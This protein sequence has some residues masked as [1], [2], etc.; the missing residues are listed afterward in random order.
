MSKGNWQ[1]SMSEDDKDLTTFITHRCMYRFT[2]MLF[3]LVNSPATFNRMMRK[4]L[5]H[6]QDVDTYIDDVLAHTC[7]WN[8]HIA[9]LRE[10]FI[11]VRNAN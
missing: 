8:D 3:S 11:R 6:V 1:A 9:A 7:Q 4:L 2:V 10:F 5:N